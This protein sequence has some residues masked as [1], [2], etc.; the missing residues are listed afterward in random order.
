MRKTVSG[1]LISISSLSISS[2][3]AD[4][5]PRPFDTQEVTERLRAPGESLAAIT[6]PKG[7]QVTLFAA[8][9]DVNQPIAIT[10]DDRGRL[11]V[12]EN[13][14]YAER[15]VN[16]ET[17]KLRD[18]I[19][20][21]EDTDHDGRH[22]RRT[23]FWDEGT[24]VTS[25]AVGYGGVWV[26][27]APN[28]LFIADRNRDDV[29]DSDPEIVL[30][31]WDDDR[32][33]HTLV[34]GLRWGPDG[35]LY[36]RH[37][38]IATSLVGT[39]ETPPEHRT[40]VDCG[41]WRFHPTRRTFEVVARGTT[42]PWGMDWDQHGQ[43]FFINTVI[44]H[45]WHVVPGAY[46]QRMYGDHFDPHVYQL[47]PQTAD[48][49]HWDTGTE[50]W[51]DIRKRGVS[52]ATSELGG[53]HAH[54]GMMIYSG[55][56]WPEEYRGLLFTCNFHGRRVNVERLERS[57]ATYVGK[58]APDFLKT[59]D[60][61]FR[62][63]DLLAGPDG[64]VYLADWS[65]IGECHENDGVHR[66]SGRIFKITYG[67]TQPLT[68]DLA[69]LSSSELVDLLRHPNEWFPRH[70]QRLLNERAVARNNMSE[71]K[72]TLLQR[73][74]EATQPRHQ[75]RYLWALHAIGGTSEAWLLEQLAH[76][77]EHVRVWAVQ[78]LV[79]Q[80]DPSTTVLAAFASQAQ[81]E[82]SGLVLSFLASALNRVP[83]GDRWT[84]ATYLA[85]HG[86]FANDP[87]YPLFVWYGIEPAV[88]EFPLQAVELAQASRLPLLRRHIARRLTEDIE[89]QPEPVA[90]LLRTVLDTSD[91]SYQ[92]DILE[93]MHAAVRG[94][95][96]AQPPAVW[97]EVE[98]KL[99]NAA[100]DLRQTVRE[101]S[102]VFGSGRAMDEVLALLAEKESP[103]DVRR[104]AVRALI[105]ARAE[106]LA[107]KLQ[108]LLRD[109][110]LDVEAIRGLAAYDHPDTPRLLIERYPQFLKPARQE[111]IA[112]L[113]S[114]PVFARALLNAVQSRTV[115]RE[116]ISPFQIRQMQTFRDTEIA[117]RIESL[118]P[119]LKA[120]PEEKQRQI[121]DY[122]SL[123]TPEY[124]SAA[125]RSAGRA[126]FKQNCAGCHQ[127]FDDG[128]RV[129][130]VL[131]GG[132]RNDLNYLLENIVD[133]SATVS[134]DYELSTLVLEDGRV[135]Q[136]IVVGQNERTL[137]LQ[138]VS[139]QR[140]GE[141]VVFEIARDRGTA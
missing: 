70:A 38:I 119:E 5:F 1:I 115:P 85:G 10:T 88:A 62:G 27:A 100:I 136:G 128:N 95:H 43:L 37:G 8:E 134:K 132:Q 114:R 2:A 69:G 97:R 50:A 6:L 45:L 120:I 77:D 108:E 106:N 138:T 103:L 92:R 48:H 29:P 110:F 56:N 42:N 73:Y 72:C 9:P 22:D 58:H 105:A 125:D 44:G 137:T 12:V 112:T 135:L 24:H 65:D 96:K 60:P 52:A 118:W 20:I 28:L 84:L 89:R 16:F 107:P 15:D 4:D 46:Y 67:P 91:D 41:I 66:T 23:V 129:G 81:T 121:A 126:L 18:R 99:A 86:E 39:P 87:Y 57:G 14:T 17:E 83:T 111:T 78:L 31:G 7:F 63:I 124:L 117:S 90:A 93:G 109:Q 54:Q 102:L 75:L 25:V 76:E 47:L 32:A 49:Y 127:L 33:R 68:R 98:L 94:W 133:P 34:N 40:Q 141:R 131:T 122:R 101:L 55:D 123:L 59:S 53:G 30:N 139:Q 21:F 36:G 130:P 26:L 35:W 140:G 51:S 104:Q 113:V 64:G 11:W 116:E 74:E 79:D 13:Y 61:W 71:V 82:T 80:P 19:L 3:I